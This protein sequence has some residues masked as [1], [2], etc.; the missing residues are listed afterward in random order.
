MPIN[1]IQIGVSKVVQTKGFR[2]VN[3]VFGAELQSSAC[4][5]E[6][7]LP[8]RP[9]PD[10]PL[11]SLLDRWPVVPM[12]Q[13]DIAEVLDARPEA[14]T[15]RGREAGAVHVLEACCWSSRSAALSPNPCWE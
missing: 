4:L 1:S 5:G 13:T 15:L 11:G 12:P 7:V 14:R 8:G 10:W 9:R 2:T 6:G 3:S